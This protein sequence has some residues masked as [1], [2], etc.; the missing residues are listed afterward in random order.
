MGLHNSLSNQYVRDRTIH[1]RKSDDQLKRKWT[2]ERL[3]WIRDRVI[4]NGHDMN[5][6][7]IEI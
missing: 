1:R 3:K 7:R 4:S 5:I 2:Q 6:L